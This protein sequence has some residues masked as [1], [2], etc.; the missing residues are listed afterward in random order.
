MKNPY[1]GKTLGTNITATYKGKFEDKKIAFATHWDTRPVADS[2]FLSKNRAKPIVGAN[3]GNSST[4]ILLALSDFLK[5]YKPKYTVQLLFFDAEDSGKDE[6]TF[7]IGS[8]Y[9]VSHYSDINYRFGMV[10]DMVGDK[11]LNIFYEGYSYRYAKVICENIWNVANNKFKYDF[12]I[13][14]KKYFLIDDHYAFL[15]KNIPVIDIIDFDYL[16]WHTLEDIPKNCSIDNMEKILK[17][18]IYVVKFP[19][20]IE[21]R[22]KY[23]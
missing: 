15:K 10:L 19:E 5:R 9:F 23:E 2:D 11:D 6:D 3:D 13:K 8:N 12:F 7:C 20:K 21:K 4:A 1:L 14:K 22:R 18:M 16:Y 17:L